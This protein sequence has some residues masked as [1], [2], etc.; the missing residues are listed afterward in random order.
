MLTDCAAM[1]V[2][3]VSYLI[4]FC[5]ERLKHRPSTRTDTHTGERLS[6]HERHYR[7]KMRLLILE[8]APPFISV[9]TLVA[10]TVIAIDQAITILMDKNL[11]D[12]G[13][14]PN[15]FLM[16]LFSSLNF[17]LDG[18]N[19]LCFSK[20]DKSNG[21]LWEGLTAAMHPKDYCDKCKA[22]H[23]P[24]CDNT[25]DGI[26]ASEKT[27]LLTDKDAPTLSME[28]ESEEEDNGS[29][30]S[31]SSR[32][33]NLNMCS[34]WTHICADTLRSIAVL[35]A[36]GFAWLFPSI[37]TPADA[38]SYGAIVVSI[39]I[40]ISLGPLIE[41]LYFTAWEIY[42]LHGEHQRRLRS[43][44]GANDPVVSLAV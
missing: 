10:V 9:S 13:P 2:D 26:V 44:E 8:L 33:L 5:A 3:C 39:I 25:P 40:I 16:L 30:G 11:A 15:L 28:E 21:Q 18:V 43:M 38:D 1:T 23:E 19:M 6:A 42:H 41:G 27:H 36:A 4:N 20:A 37:L 22:K 31:Q 29:D 35:I 14:Q 24:P 12:K 17:V 7:K 34:A 32:G